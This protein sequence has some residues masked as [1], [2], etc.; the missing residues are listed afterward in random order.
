[1]LLFSV[2]N[3]GFAQGLSRNGFNLDNA[4]VNTSE[5]QSGGVLRDV[6]PALMDPKFIAPAEAHF[7]RDDDRVL[8]VSFAGETRAYP[9]KI[10]NYHEI[11][12]DTFGS[13]P[14]AISWCPLCGSGIVFG[15]LIDNKR[16]T[17]GVSGLLFNSD[18]LMYDHASESLWSQFVGLAITGPMKGMRLATV[19]ASNTTWS[20]WLAQHP[21]TQVLSDEQ[22]YDQFN[23]G[24]NSYLSY[25]SNRNI[26]FPIRH[27]SRKFAPKTSVIGVEI[28]QQFKAYPFKK[29][30]KKQNRIEDEFAGQ[31]IVIEYDRDLKTGRVLNEAGEEIPSFTAYWF[32][33][34]SFHPNTEIY[35]K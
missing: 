25:E 8:G 6:I 4:L 20:A 15:A 34:Y 30:P 24:V 17:F 12:N 22:G 18:L 19:P 29:L 10:L 3:T 13:M 9:I 21:E 33:W 11:V 7:L 28:N 5:I 2:T 26:R 35:P 31:K 27:N 32:A 1:M 23:Y 16:R 14:L